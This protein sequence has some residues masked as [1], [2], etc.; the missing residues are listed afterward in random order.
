VQRAGYVQVVSCELCVVSCELCVVDPGS[1]SK[2]TCINLFFIASPAECMC[3][4]KIALGLISVKGL[5]DV[6][7]PVIKS[8]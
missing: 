3:R 2:S 1:E 7:K 8:N 5:P 4:N 6:V